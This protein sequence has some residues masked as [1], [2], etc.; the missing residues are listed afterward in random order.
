MKIINKEKFAKL[1]YQFEHP[2]RVAL[3][4]RYPFLKMPILWARRFVR[5]VFLYAQPKI[6]K[7]KQKEFFKNVLIRHQ[8]PLRRRLG[9]SDPI[10]QEKKIQNLKLAIE[11]MNGVVIRPGEI[12]SYW[13]ILGNPTYR[14]GFVDG[15]LLSDGKVVEGVGGGLCQ[16]SNL[17]YWMFLHVDAEIIERYHHS[18]DVFPDSGRTLPFGSG[19]T[20]MY[21]FIDLQA[22]NTSN[23]DMQIKLWLTDSQLSGQILSSQPS[24]FK[25]HIY[26]K[27]HYFIKSGDK[28][29][30]YN[31]IWRQKKNNGEVVADEL[32]VENFAPVMY[33]V[34]D[35]YLKKHNFKVVE[36]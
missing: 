1:V 26:E 34:D 13:K 20:V 24:E 8:S 18:R 17:L 3:S 30:R 29:F 12:F 10:L 33:K 36:V 25:V 31:Q 28:Y 6:T 35:D 9:S 15:M 21:N 27:E 22:R 11:E 4:R 14:R 23:A 32:V 5:N 19:A 7:R 16:L 2:G